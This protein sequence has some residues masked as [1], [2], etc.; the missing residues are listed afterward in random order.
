MLVHRSATGCVQEPETVE[1]LCAALVGNLG[2][3]TSGLLG[4]DGGRAAARA[5]A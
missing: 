4:L 5:R 1:L 3:V 2:G